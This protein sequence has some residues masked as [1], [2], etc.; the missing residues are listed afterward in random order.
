MKRK[1]QKL[2]KNII[3]TVIFFLIPIMIK[4]LN[5][6]TLELVVVTLLIKCIDKLYSNFKIGIILH[7]YEF[8]LLSLIN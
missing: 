6:N 7:D 5:L 8:R 4:F 3:F 1:K 2:I